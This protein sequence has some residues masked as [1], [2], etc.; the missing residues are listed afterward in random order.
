M[1]QNQTPERCGK[2]P[3]IRPAADFLEREDGFYL[4]LD[5]PGVR[6]EDLVV[7]IE[8]DELT[9][10]ARTSHRQ[11]CGER[12]HAMEFGD[13]EYHAQFALTDTMDKL[14]IGAQLVNGVLRIVIPH[15]EE[16]VPRRITIEVL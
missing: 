11:C 9:I 7:H 10:N 15:R 16:Q 4:F 1:H 12:V 13:V 14:N 3:R 6:R 8:D 2:A 5:M